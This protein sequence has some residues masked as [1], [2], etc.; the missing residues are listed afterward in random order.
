MGI[1]RIRR[2]RQRG[3]SIILKVNPADATSESQRCVPVVNVTRWP[4]SGL[5]WKCFRAACALNQQT[6]P[7][8]NRTLGRVGWSFEN[9]RTRAHFLRR[10]SRQSAPF[11]FLR[12]FYEFGSRLP[13]ASKSSAD[14]S[15]RPLCNRNE[16]SRAHKQTRHDVN[17]R[18]S[19]IG[20]FD[21]L[22]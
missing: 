14:K 22:F 2:R 4:N 1:E 8:P 7:K 13:S 5:S 3:S 11:P 20:F 6:R 16:R 18:K 12:P 9:V 15:G 21:L 17:S 10:V 19:F